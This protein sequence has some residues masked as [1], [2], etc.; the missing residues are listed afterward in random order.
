[1]NSAPSKLN[2]DLL[3]VLAS[4][5]NSEY[6]SDK[7]ENRVGHQV[8]TEGLDHGFSKQKVGGLFASGNKLGLLSSWRDEEGDTCCLTQ[9]GMDA[10]K[11]NGLFEKGV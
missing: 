3:K 7:R 4:I 11:A 10:L 8:W 9:A 5:L 1:M 2:P 6:H